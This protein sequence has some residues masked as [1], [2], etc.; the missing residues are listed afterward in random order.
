MSD[1]LIT[2]K[3]IKQR[4]LKLWQT[5][6]FHRA[7]LQKTK[8]FPVEIP[9]KSISAKTLLA[10]FSAVQDLISELR[11]DSKKQ[12]YIISD[13]SI[14]HRQ[15]GEQ[16]IPALIS[17]NLE[18]LFL[19]YIGKTAEFSQ[20]KLLATQSLQQDGLLLDWLIRYPLKVMKYADVWLQLLKVC[21]YFEKH[22]QPD[23]YI[24]QLDIK[25]VDSKFIE[26]HKSILNELL[27]E[28][29]AETNYDGNVMGLSHHGFERRYG[30]RFDPPLIRFRILD[31]S[32]AI[33]GLTDL[34]LTL[35]EF[36]QMNIE[37]STVF[38]AE[39][40]I[41]GLAFPGHTQAIV[42]FGLGYAVKLLADV[43]WLQGK[44]LYYWGDLDIDGLAIL[45]RLRRYYPQVK[46]LLMNL[47][48][49]EQF[50][51][52]IEKMPENKSEKTLEYL[53]KSEM[54]LYS[55]LQQ[56]SLRLEQ[57]RIS[58]AYLKRAIEGL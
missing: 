8:R 34:T 20:F 12:G 53:S 49:L 31:K 46:S 42:I 18:D 24:R 36:K 2:P 40:K 21:D 39:N 33:N 43:D 7:W 48:T 45:S 26:Q 52:L 17:F 15:L 30:L 57:E 4:A 3:A 41:N 16:K 50:S 32:L 56:E 47:K 25:D 14:S 51:D 10:N 9:I 11:A 35:S 5:G 6:V 44:T 19:V 38:I 13:K 54:D 29:L 55:K 23:C 58:F 1:F 28:M 22:P 37:V 27:T